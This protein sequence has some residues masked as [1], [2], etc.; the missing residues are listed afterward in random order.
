MTQLI[1]IMFV[2]VVIYLNAIKLNDLL[3]LYRL[4]Q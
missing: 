3:V 1:S 2:G 4:V